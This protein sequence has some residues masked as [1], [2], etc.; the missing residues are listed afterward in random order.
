ME[1]QTLAI[2]KPDVLL[3][4]MMGFAIS[5]IEQSFHIKRMVLTNFTSDMAEGFYAEH[6]EKPFFQ[7]IISDMT[8]GPVVIMILSG[9][10]VIKRW[11]DAMGA[12]D[13]KNAEK[14]TLRQQFGVSIG[15]NS[16]H[17]SLTPEDA[18]R[19]IKLLFS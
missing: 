19:E 10:N 1:Q 14:G 3:R 6:K 16:F 5:I 13:P 15:L 9:E 2:I 8:A 12:T 17:G 4:N 11:R 7:E 18:D